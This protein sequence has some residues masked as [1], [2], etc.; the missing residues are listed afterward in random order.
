M[1]GLIF[2]WQDEWFKRTW[3][4]VDYDDPDRRPY[5]S[6][7][8]TNEQRFRILSFD[9][10][11]VQIDGKT[12]EWQEEEPLLTTEDLTLHVKSDETYLYLTIKS[13][14][15]EKENVR[16]LLD[17]VANQGNTS[18]RETG[19]QFPAPVEYLV[20]LNQQGESRIV[21]DVYYDCFNY[22]YAK[23]LSMLPDRMPNPQKDSGQFSTIDFVLNKALTLPDSQKKIPF[24]FYRIRGREN[25][26][27]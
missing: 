15:L 17:T 16:I 1:G 6:N 8:Q 20:K 10:N 19:D 11:L 5:W 27:F 4:T 2:S 3:N 9:R 18:D 25:P 14:Q 24:S 12:D 26:L 23:K 13:K 21:Q 22:L 7:V